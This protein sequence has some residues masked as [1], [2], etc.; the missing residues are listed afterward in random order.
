MDM[1]VSLSKR[2]VSLFNLVVNPDEFEKWMVSEAAAG[3]GAPVRVN[4]QPYSKANSRRFA[5]FRRKNGK[6]GL[7]SIKSENAMTFD[8]IAK[9]SKLCYQNGAPYQEDVVFYALLKYRTRRSDVDESLLLDSLQGKCYL[10]DRQV[11]AKVIIGKIEKDS[12][13]AT[14][15]V[16]P[17]R[18]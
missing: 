10:N 17:I 12:P 8:A 13:G 6:V 11:R 9:L 2:V 3:R 16:K 14:V 15:L 1:E 7:R 4:H 5:T 18:S